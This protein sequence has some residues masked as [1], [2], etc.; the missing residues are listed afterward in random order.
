MFIMLGVS[1]FFFSRNLTIT[2]P[3]PS[4]IAPKIMHKHKTRPQKCQKL[5]KKNSQRYFT[6]SIILLYLDR[7]GK[8]FRPK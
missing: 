8:H 3:I 6:I 5:Q 7:W 4:P 2:L 1:Y